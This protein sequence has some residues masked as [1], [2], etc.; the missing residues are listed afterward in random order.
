MPPETQQ[1]PQ[2][3]AFKEVTAGLSEQQ[4]AEFFKTLHEAG[5]SPN[6]VELAR[7]LR[8]LQLYKA[9]YEA[10]PAEIQKAAAEIKRLKEEI[11]NL[12]R[13][14]HQCS[15][16]SAQLV[17][18]VIQETERVRKD[19]AQIHEIIE[20]GVTKSSENLASRMAGLF[21]AG[22]EKTV[23]SPLQNRLAAL[24]K[25]SEAFDGAIARSN[26]AA[27][28]LHQHV[29]SARRLHFKTYAFC[30]LVLVCSLIG[31]SYYYLYRRFGDQVV[32]ERQALVGLTDKNS[33]VLLQLTKSH[34]MLEL[35]PDPEHPQRKLLVM[36][37]AFGWQSTRH[38]GVIEFEE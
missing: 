30:G 16:T 13:D 31:G 36:K 2:Q 24:A 6:D 26:Q 23:V 1:A 15:D 11:E 4:Q 20:K 21:S 37:D 9:Y 14:A 29:A 34:R 18:Q 35:H 17:G 3:T 5:I 12:S 7:L 32:Q 10:I 19:L 28:T 38:E 33:S 25:S 27:A 22:I 8:A